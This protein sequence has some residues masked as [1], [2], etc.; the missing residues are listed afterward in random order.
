VVADGTR[1][2][3]LTRSLDRFVD[4]LEG[5]SVGKPLASFRPTRPEPASIAASST[6]CGNHSRSLSLS[7]SLLACSI[8]TIPGEFESCSHSGE[9]TCQQI[10]YCLH[11][12]TTTI[13]IRKS[14]NS[15]CNCNITYAQNVQSLDN[16]KSRV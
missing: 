8:H 13:L 4:C 3:W 2:H 1:T 10:R 16:D 9:L 15:S 11:Y 6:P 5:S 7:L 14:S 12:T